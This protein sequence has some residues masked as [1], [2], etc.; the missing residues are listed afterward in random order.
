MKYTIFIPPEV[1]RILDKLR[2][3]DPNLFERIGKQTEKILRNPM[4]GKPMRNVL[5]N[6]RRVHIDPF[7]L[8]YEIKD[9]QIWLIDFDHHDRIYRKYSKV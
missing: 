8:M 9:K 6:Y 7:V 2:K 1:E 4:F 5:R 3:S